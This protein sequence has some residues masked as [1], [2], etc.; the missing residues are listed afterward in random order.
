MWYCQ[1]IN[2]VSILNT[3][4]S[5]CWSS[6]WWSYSSSPTTLLLPSQS[7]SQRRTNQW[8]GEAGTVTQL[9]ADLVH[10]LTDSK[11]VATVLISNLLNREKLSMIYKALYFS[12]SLGIAYYSS[13]P[14]TLA[15]IV[16]IFSA[17]YWK[18]NLEILLVL[19][20]ECAETQENALTNRQRPRHSLG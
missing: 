3:D 12:H 20:K 2:T 9:T 6:S 19:G 15:N 16:H 7:W 13:P 4:I 18:W 11:V 10:L 5:W 14:R 17:G 8:N 1:L